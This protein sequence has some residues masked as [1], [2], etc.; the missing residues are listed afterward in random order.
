MPKIR[1]SSRKGISH[2]YHVCTAYLIIL[3]GSWQEVEEGS[4][5]LDGY[6]IKIGF[7]KQGAK[8]RLVQHRREIEIHIKGPHGGGL[9]LL[10][11]RLCEGEAQEKEFHALMARK[12]PELCICIVRNDGVDSGISGFKTECYDYDERIIQEFAQFFG[13][14]C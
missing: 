7:T 3:D 13:P 9:T 11:E 14:K 1:P 10:D 4:P 5:S 8:K 12:Y 6:K 2:P